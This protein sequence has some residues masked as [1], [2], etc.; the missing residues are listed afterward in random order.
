MIYRALLVVAALLRLRHHWV[1]PVIIVAVLPLASCFDEADSN[2][3]R[4]NLPSLMAQAGDVSNAEVYQVLLERFVEGDHFSE[5]SGSLVGTSLNELDLRP[6]A[7]FERV[8]AARVGQAFR[9]RGY[10]AVIYS[11]AILFP[12]KEEASVFFQEVRTG[13]REHD[14][15]SSNPAASEVGELQHELVGEMSLGPGDGCG[16]EVV[17]TDAIDGAFWL[18]RSAF[19]RDQTASVVDDIITLHKS[20]VWL[21][22]RVPAFATFEGSRD[23]FE[24]KFRALVLEP[25]IRRMQAWSGD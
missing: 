19:A 3:R 14:W 5:L 4:G 15:E 10:P 23:L 17:S 16:D 21:L 2:D 7:A 12:S 18:H 1:A 24:C 13:S 20:S 11:V 9:D 25:A 8:V 6:T 22:V